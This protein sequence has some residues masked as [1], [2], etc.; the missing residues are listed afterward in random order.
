M[1]TSAA[2]TEIAY[3]GNGVTQAFAFPFEV[4]KASH[5]EATIDG[6]VTTAYTL[7]GLGVDA[8]GTCTFTVAPTALAVIVLARVVPYARSDFD[9]QEGG[10]LAAATLDD[11]ID[12]ENMQIQQLATISR[13]SIRAPRGETLAELP[14]AADRAN[15][16]LYFDAT[17][18]P[19]AVNTTGSTAVSS[20]MEPVVTAAD[21][22]TARNLMGV[23]F[24]G[25]S[26]ISIEASASAGALTISL[27]GDDGND[28]S[29][30][31]PGS[32]TTF[33]TATGA[34]QL[35]QMTLTSA[36]AITVPSGADVGAVAGVPFRLWIAAFNRAGVFRL[37]VINPLQ[38]FAGFPHGVDFNVVNLPGWGYSDSIATLDTASDQSGFFYMTSPAGAVPRAYMLL[39]CVEYH[40]GLATPGTWTTPSSVCVWRP[41][42]PTP[43]QTLMTYGKRINAVATGTTVLPID[44]TIPTSS[45]GVEFLTCGNGFANL[46]PFSLSCNLLSVRASLVL[47]SSNTDNVI[48][49]AMF[50]DTEVDAVAA[51]VASRPATAGAMCQVDVEYLG[52][53]INAAG[54]SEI[55]EVKIRA[56]TASAGTTTFNGTAGA[57]RFGGRMGSQIV[58]Q[59]I[60]T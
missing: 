50:F 17:G 5:F 6:V 34:G 28:H 13:R 3:A 12:D 53:N 56:G 19:T 8:G 42:M 60:M 4:R 10:E 37:A 48:G 20:A 43:G 55:G 7:S 2:D 44:D 36:Q 29:A 58:V 26:N 14:S 54:T 32:V 27:K 57:R 59:Q 16:T 25:P 47:A 39:G 31:N 38:V 24:A 33:S 11:D 23:Q 41:G 40:A 51:G 9:Y 52:S 21:L 46:S 18:A 22:E 30:S 35:S 15:T 1:P 49:A 45:E